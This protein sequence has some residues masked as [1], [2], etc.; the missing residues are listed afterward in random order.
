M[1]GLTRSGRYV[2]FGGG[3]PS[4]QRRKSA[5]HRED[6]G[7]R[8]PF[9]R[10]KRGSTTGVSGKMRKCH[11]VH[12]R[13]C[14]LHSDPPQAVRQDLSFWARTGASPDVGH[15][16]VA[17][18]R[19]PTSLTSRKRSFQQLLKKNKNFAEF[20]QILEAELAGGPGTA[21]DVV[22]SLA[23]VAGPLAAADCAVGSGEW[24]EPPHSPWTLR[25]RGPKKAIF[26]LFSGS[27][28]QRKMGPFW[29]LFG[30]FLALFG[31]LFWPFWGPFLA[32]FGPMSLLDPRA[33]R[34]AIGCEL[35]C[36]RSWSHPSWPSYGQ[37]GNGKLAGDRP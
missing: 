11:A 10:A 34:N 37:V 29:P 2:P 9:A 22:P 33:R 13:P 3:P 31:A 16:R 26:C 35:R 30:P 27:R 32:L 4:R 12:I 25:H 6:A 14:R 8:R 36:Q 15:I 23:H 24:A 17:N 20:R 21:P 19:H 1:R 18:C 28:G 7:R 5:Q